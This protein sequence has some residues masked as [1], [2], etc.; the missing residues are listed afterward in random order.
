[1]QSRLPIAHL[2]GMGKTNQAASLA[3]FLTADG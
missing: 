1:M 2:D 3:I